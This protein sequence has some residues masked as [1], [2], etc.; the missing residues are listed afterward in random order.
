MPSLRRAPSR[1]RHSLLQAATATLAITLAPVTA[2]AAEMAPP[3][4]PAQAA[5]PAGGFFIGAGAGYNHFSPRHSGIYATGLSEVYRD[6]V[7]A[8]TGYA[9][10]GTG[11][12]LHERNAFAPVG[13]IGYMGS[14]GG[15]PW[16]WGVRATYNYVGADGDARNALVPQGGGFQSNDPGATFAGNLLVRQYKVSLKHQFALLPVA[17]YS[18][19]RIA[20]YGGAGPSLSQTRG[21]MNGVIGFADINGNRQDITGAPVNFAKSRWTY[22]LAATAGVIWRLDDHWFI[23]A[24]YVYSRTRRTRDHFFA[25]FVNPSNGF[26]YTGVGLGSHAASTVNHAVNIS[27]NYAFWQ[28]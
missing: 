17:G 25:P 15:S 24:T 4:A 23:D 21:E 1:T 14:I 3:P 12:P 2:S 9:T 13:Q 27:L 7:L 20:L 10:G 22:G 19:G 5:T 6:G 28:P 18:F 8:A 11:V 16:L 26:V